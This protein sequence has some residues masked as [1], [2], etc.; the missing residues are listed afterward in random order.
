MHIMDLSERKILSEDGL[1]NVDFITCTKR[2][3]GISGAWYNYCRNGES[4]SKSYNP[5]RFLRSMVFLGELESRLDSQMDQSEYRIYLN[6][7]T[8]GFARILCCQ[9]IMRGIQENVSWRKVRARL[10]EICCRR[11]IK[12]ALKHY[13]WY[14]LPPKQAMFAFLVKYRLYF[15][16]KI[17][18]KLRLGQES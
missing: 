17:L 10:K 3:V 18:V 14:K 6:R 9:E 5:T 11:E 1:F 7:L 8:Q 15:L 16:Q 2:A 13:P 12:Q 4:V